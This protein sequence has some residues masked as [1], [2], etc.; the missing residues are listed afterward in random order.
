MALEFDAQLNWPSTSGYVRAC[1]K[2]RN[3]AALW[4]SVFRAKKA[5]FCGFEPIVPRAE[6]FWPTDEMSAL[7][8]V[9]PVRAS[10]Y[11]F[12]VHL[13]NEAGVNTPKMNHYTDVREIC[14]P[15][16]WLSKKIKI[17][18]FSGSPPLPRKLRIFHFWVNH[19]AERYFSP[20]S[21][22]QNLLFKWKVSSF[23]TV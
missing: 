7:S 9:K 2:R 10:F 12:S 20:R 13:I 22:N 3:L 19:S 1:P 5:E 21:I 23:L 15:A 17:R 18:N 14:R 16:S 8:S 6:I 4:E 11:F